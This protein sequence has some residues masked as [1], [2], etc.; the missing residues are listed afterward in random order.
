LLAEKLFQHPENNIKNIYSVNY[1]FLINILTPLDEVATALQAEMHCAY[2]AEP[3][4]D[5]KIRII[6]NTHIIVILV[7][8]IFL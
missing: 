2:S 3:H 8:F 1:T 5:I 7:I 6:M 4:S